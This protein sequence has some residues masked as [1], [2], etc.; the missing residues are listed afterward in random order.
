VMFVVASRR[1]TLVGATTTASKH[2]YATPRRIRWMLKY[3]LNDTQLVQFGGK[4]SLQTR[5]GQLGIRTIGY[6]KVLR[7]RL[8]DHL[9]GQPGYVPVPPVVVYQGFTKIHGPSGF[10]PKKDGTNEMMQQSLDKLPMN[11]AAQKKKMKKVREPKKKKL[12][13]GQ[14]PQQRLPDIKIVG[15]KNLSSSRLNKIRID[16]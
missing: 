9:K 10:V 7:E 11:T 3:P 15:T 12:K 1:R 16:D 13:E 5:L 2:N 14:E 6:R 4:R 8:H